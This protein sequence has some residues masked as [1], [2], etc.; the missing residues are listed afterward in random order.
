MKDEFQHQIDQI[1]QLSC[2]DSLLCDVAIISSGLSHD[3]FKVQAEHL[4]THERTHYFV[5]SLTAH[6]TTE[7]NERLATQLAGLAFISPA[8]V[9]H[10]KDWLVTEF[11]LGKSL[12]ESDISLSDKIHFSMMLLAKFHQLSPAKAITPFSIKQLIDKHIRQG[13]FTQSQHRYLAY[14]SQ[15]LT[16]FATG[17]N[18]VLCHGDVNFANVMV[19]PNNR[20]WLID[21]ECAFIGDAE[22]D[23]AMFIAVNQLPLSLISMIISCYEEK[24]GMTLNHSLVHSYLACCYLLNG[25]W[26]QEKSQQLNAP[27]SYLDL[28]R[29]QYQQFDQLTL[30]SEKLVEKLL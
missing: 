25:L 17:E 20:P 28:A 13:T 27:S 5:K 11:I 9:F 2:F 22:C 8:T 3:C 1:K 23:I 14:L 16:D 21:F 12:V 26:Y 18:F 29:E 4:A 19:D 15:Q 24:G 30:A 7:N 10:S 6:P